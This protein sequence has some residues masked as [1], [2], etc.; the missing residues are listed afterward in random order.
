MLHNRQSTGFTIVELLIVI[1]VIGILAAITIVAFNGV[2]NKA[3]VAAAQSS[4]N[5]AKKQVEIARTTNGTD[6]YPLS[7]TGLDANVTYTAKATLGGYCL[8]NGSAAKE[9]YMATSSN[10]VPHVGPSTITDGCK[11]QNIVTNPSF[12][13]NAF[14]WDKGAQAAITQITDPAHVNVGVGAGLLR[15]TSSVAGEGYT[16]MNMA[17]V[18]GKRYSV[19]FAVKNY[20]GAPAITASVRNFN[21]GWSVADNA[22]MN[23]TPTAS[24]VRYTLNWTAQDTTSLLLVENMSTVANSAIVIDAVMATEGENAGAYIDPDLKPG[25][26]WAWDNPNA[27]GYSTSTGPAF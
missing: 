5:G 3:K 12:E 1:V 22:I 24:Y 6:A 4:L 8:V 2:S 14:N 20:S 27:Q 17:T 25:T 26:G 16:R 15:R 19:S 7:M 13:F 21:M 9:P 18:V 10:G 11:I 23:I